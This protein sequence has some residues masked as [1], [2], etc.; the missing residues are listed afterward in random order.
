MFGV[1]RV[2]VVDTD[3][4]QS[5]KCG[6]V[7]MVTFAAKTECAELF[8]KRFEAL[9]GNAPFP[10]QEC[11]FLRFL[12]DKVPPADVSLPTGTGKTSIMAI[13]L[14]ALAETSSVDSRQNSI[15]RRLTWIV[16]RRVVV[17]QATN[18]VEQ[19]RRRVND[20]AIGELEPIRSALRKLSGE[21]SGEILG[22]STLRGQFEDNAEW[23]GNP[24]RP[25]VIVG[26]VDMIGSRLLFSGY[27]AG[28]KSKPLHAGFL[29]Q[30]VL[31]VHDEA[32]L[33]PA[34]QELL[35]TI[36][37]EQKRCRE[38]G[39]F[40]VMAL[41]ATS[42]AKSGVF[43]LTEVEK[44][45]P[46]EMPAPSETPLH[47]IWRRQGAKKTISLH[48]NKE[49]GKL[50]NEIADLALDKKFKDSGRAILVFVRKVEDVK[51]IAKQLKS[52]NQRVRPFTGTMRGFERD[53]LVKEDAIFRRFLPG[54]E[55]D[56]TTVYL[57][58]TSAGEVGVNISA[59]HLICD[60]SP[61]DGMVQRFGRVNRFGNRDDTEIHVVYPVKFEKDND[62]DDRRQ[63][64]LEL[65]KKLPDGQASPI[66]LGELNAED[67]QAAFTPTPKIFSATDIL[68]DSW[69]LTTIRGKLPGRPAVE[70]YLHGVSEYEPPET[71]VAWREEVGIVSGKLL[72][73]Y[74]PEELLDA[75]PLK[76]LELLRDRS[77]RVLKYL[78]ELAKRL[79]EAPVWLLTDDGSVEV[80]TL[81]KLV[82]DNNKDRINDSTVLLPP[83]VGG[84]SEGSLDGVS[85]IA[86]EVADRWRDASGT[87]RRIRVWDDDRQLSG[88]INGMRL[89]RTIDTDSGTDDELE[90]DEVV[91]HRYWHWYELPKVADNDGSE[92]DAGAVLWQVH[93][94]D[95]VKE[96]NRIVDQ[97]PLSDELRNA[98]VVAA[99]FH[100]YGKRR[101]LF[102]RIIGN[103]NI[104]TLLAKSGRKKQPY[105][106]NDSYRHEF[107]SLLDV[108]NESEFLELSEDMKEVV[109]HLVATH[110]GRG[111]PHFPAEEAYD[112][113]ATDEKNSII[114]AQVPQRFARLQRKYGR[115]G[116]AY[117]ESLLRAADYAASANPSAFWAGER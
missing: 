21:T 111:R 117:L 33:E 42:R 19:I 14:L 116:L 53:N 101:P 104:N 81:E 95:V 9:T 66:A 48:E 73:Q 1:W 86:D 38:F 92:R 58:C 45:I 43:G 12:S 52:A 87:Q 11:L 60:L 37:E 61:F 76:P 88:K 56:G 57:V 28:F 31:L 35:I 75:Y 30:D 15:P 85:D 71:H 20:P 47:V 25:A 109:L 114:A 83:S 79:P 40:H 105:T 68:F 96:A 89:I 107:A 50:A 26:T 91:S 99:R 82:N 103:V 41:S 49:E 113:E 59:D 65:L 98:V 115:W 63:R 17:D 24:S 55:A 10:W 34:F 106:L 44:N 29:G 112:P 2:L 13:W 97:L 70:P 62:L 18:E 22:I 5:L 108:Q 69:A 27:G 93:T 4:V 67:C 78:K 100:D 72:E 39:K 16:N 90:E 94:D 6:N 8:A 36:R 7:L 80:F 110:H 64:T 84:L 102:Q 74:D 46:Y 77:D 51:G 54:A 32:H 23:R 3:Q